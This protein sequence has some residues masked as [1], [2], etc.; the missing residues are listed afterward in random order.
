MSVSGQRADVTDL[1]VVVVVVG[2]FAGGR[3][4]VRGELREATKP[5]DMPT[6]A[7]IVATAARTRNRLCRAASAPATRPREPGT[8]RRTR[9]TNGIGAR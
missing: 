2:W 7:R 9:R 4:G 5:T 1:A 8:Y 6:R 3:L